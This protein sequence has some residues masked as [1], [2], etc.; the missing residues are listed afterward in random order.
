MKIG[1]QVLSLI[2][3]MIC[4]SILWAQTAGPTRVVKSIR[5]DK[6]PALRDMVQA[7]TPPAQALER[8]II[9][10]RESPLEHPI[11]DSPFQP[12]DPH[13]QDFMG[14]QS[15]AALLLSFDGADALDNP[16]GLAPPD[17]NGDVGPGH[18]VQMVNLVT[19]I[20]DK[21]GTT[22]LGPFPSS[23]FWAGF[24]GPCETFNDGDP[25]V[26]YDPIADRWVVSQFA[27]SGVPTAECIACSSTPDP[28]GTY[29]R[30]EFDF[31]ADFPDY[32]KLGVWPGA[33]AGT[34]RNFPAG[35]GFDMLAVAFERDAMLIGAPA[36]MI[37]FSI[38]ALLPGTSAEG[39]LPADLDGPPPAAGTPIPFIGH[40]DDGWTGAP[41]DRLV[42]FEMVPDFA[43]PGSSTFT[44]PDFLPVTPFD[45]L[46]GG[47]PFGSTIPQPGT[48]NTLDVL[49]AFTMF[50]AQT[51]D[52]GAHMSLVTNHTVDVGGDHA[53]IRWYELRNSGAGWSI[54]QEGTYAP[55]ADHR[56]MGSVAMNGSGDI[57]LGFTV[58]SSSTFPSIRYTGHTAGAPP[59]VMDV[60]EGSIFPGT[61]S[62]TSPDR[63][64]DYSSMSVDPS[65]DA[66]FWYTHEYYATTSAF[67]WKTRV[68]HFDLAPGAPIP[69]PGLLYGST[70]GLGD[71]LIVVDPTTGAGTPVGPTTGFGPVTEI[72]FRDDA[73]L[74]GSTGGGTAS[75]ITI[76]PATGVPT[77]IGV[78]PF[79]SLTGL[80]FDAGGTLFGAFFAG[81]GTP[82]DLVTVDQT[83]AALTTIGPT[84]FDKVG[85]LAFDPAGT[86]FGTTVLPGGGA[87]L[88]TIDPTTGAGT[89]VGPTGFAEVSSLEFSPDGLTLYGGLG[90]ADPLGGN[91]VTIDPTTG[92]GTL[93]GPSSFP[94]LSG[95]SFF[96]TPPT[97]LPLG[98][99]DFVEVPLPFSFPFCGTSYSSV[100]V[101]SNGYLTFGGGDFDFSESVAELLSGLPRIAP[102]WD[103][104]NPAAGGTVTAGPTG[105]DFFVEF[106]AVPEFGTANNNT[107]RIVLRPDGTYNVDYPNIDALDG[108]VGRSPGGGAA[109]P[110][111][112]DLSAAPQPIAPGVE[113]VYEIFTA[114]DNDLS[115]ANL[116]F[117]PCG[118]VLADPVIAVSPTSF[119]FT[120]PV[121]GTDSDVLSISN[122][123]T[124]PATDLT[125]SITDFVPPLSLAEG[126]KAP[127]RLRH[128]SLNPNRQPAGKSTL[129]RPEKVAQQP[130]AY[131][132]GKYA[133]SIGPAPIQALGALKGPGSDSPL[134]AVQPAWSIEQVNDFLTGFDLTTPDNLPNNGPE[135]TPGV[136][137]NAGDFGV[138]DQSFFYSLDTGNSLVKV[139]TASGTVTTLGTVAPLNGA[140]TWTGMAID[141]ND[142]TIFAVSCDVTTTDLYTID[143]S[144]PSATFIGTIPGAPCV[145][146]IAIDGAGD[147]WGYD[148]VND[149]FIS[150]DRTTA[151]RTLIGPIG[152]DANFGQGMDWDPVTDQ[153]YM[154]AFNNTAFQ[155]ELRTVDRTTGATTFLGVL[156]STNPGGLTQLAFLAIPGGAAV[157]C[158]WLSVS[159]TSGTVP[160]GSTDPVTVTVDATGLAPGI[161][162][163]NLK[164]HSN[165]PVTP[166]VIVPVTLNVTGG[167]GGTVVGEVS[168]PTS[169]PQNCPITTSVTVDMSGS[170]APDDLLGS[171]TATLS[172]DPTLLD[173]TSH[174]GILSGFTGVVNV[175]EVNGIITFNG[176]NPAGVGGVVALLDVNFDVIGAA[177]SS[178][179]LDLNFSAMAAAITFTDLLP[180]LT[181]NDC[182]VGITTPG[183]LG[184]VNGDDL[185]NSTDA[186]IILSFD[187]GIPIPQPFLDRINAGFGDVNGDGPT[188]STDALIVL[189]FDVGI[190][191]PFPVG[192][193]F[194]P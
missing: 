159:P 62:Q 3:L 182:S 82:S 98:D 53:G 73:T 101:G 145:I 186:L 97:P 112:T 48:G 180:G 108:L 140:H 177:G 144:V 71:M 61:G 135:P 173:F 161:Y 103:D 34:I 142:G 130:P 33:Y 176:A 185:V 117:G 134:L 45:A 64:G 18:Y 99:D 15:P 152:F 137:D 192:D 19:T 153:L 85:G 122:V 174:S 193:P 4:T 65:D 166:N 132:K 87:A 125:Y 81:P 167:G 42:M 20:F 57:A 110:G 31:G 162:D 27:V 1:R 94:A 25:I 154:A 100:F 113:T 83:T 138:T 93:V 102:L 189:S 68:G 158:P 179:L 121:G 14:S 37:V 141:P 96:P 72:E 49:P 77:L 35:G 59:G 78:H 114:S 47:S 107:F 86:L 164:V 181:V 23:A 41:S 115:G 60:P 92:A 127:L 21:A 38:S 133:T 131:Q 106:D 17:P 88:I 170:P 70:G 194:C 168:C 111:E 139:D 116:E 9:P 175:D 63:W 190:P 172:Y 184:D 36:G 151:A 54:F 76:D 178:A 51:R 147:L 55:D 22:L 165:D 84:G 75:L 12:A 52:F 105:P 187:A 5:N 150:I 128:Q 29:F 58:S 13:L 143:P 8:Q 183:L 160:A 2:A 56:W 6:S 90:G 126:G 191:V 157:D 74:F 95:L 69:M 129:N 50:R 188:N 66:T 30:Y 11:I 16:G 91:L 156:G 26:L 118:T 123:A 10:L 67:N 28:T 7:Y 104:L 24:G 136:F 32:P 39:F 80:E 119:T 120:V 171:F 109:D 169:A 124:P 43:S 46:F 163:C 146:G 40:Q 79:G 148:L 44:G 155:A 89:L 149:D